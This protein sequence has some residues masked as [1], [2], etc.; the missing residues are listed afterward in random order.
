MWAMV[1]VQDAHH[2]EEEQSLVAPFVTLMEL[3]LAQIK[4]VTI[5]RV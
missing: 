3:F 5:Y 4:S 1:E 2:W